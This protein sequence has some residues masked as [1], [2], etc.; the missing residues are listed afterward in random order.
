MP[1]IALFCR[2]LRFMILPHFSCKKSE[3]IA[4]HGKIRHFVTFNGSQMVVKVGAKNYRR[5]VQ[6]P[7]EKVPET[8]Q[9]GANYLWVGA[10]FL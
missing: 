8:H 4:N 10:N 6:I 7:F 9:V 3:K 1:R 5:W 2:V